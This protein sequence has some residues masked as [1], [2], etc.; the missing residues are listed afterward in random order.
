M[1]SPTPDRNRR[2]RASHA[3]SYPNAVAEPSP[4]GL[5]GADHRPRHRPSAERAEAFLRT[6]YK[7][8]CCRAPGQRARSDGS[9]RLC[10]TT[11][12][13]R[14]LP[15]IFETKHRAD[16]FYG[17]WAGEHS[18]RP[19]TAFSGF[20]ERRHHQQGN[21]APRKAIERGNER[22]GRH[23]RPSLQGNCRAT[24]CGALE[25]LV[26]PRRSETYLHICG[27]APC[28]YSQKSG[29]QT[30]AVIGGLHPPGWV[31]QPCGSF[32][33]RHRSSFF[34]MFRQAQGRPSGVRPRWRP[35]LP[36][37][38]EPLHPLTNQPL[39]VQ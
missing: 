29:R 1:S 7:G 21:R 13:R 28:E 22:H 3:S 32:R 5:P 23:K 14:A 8:R 19:F 18:F 25:V 6:R 31:R 36:V 33:K 27:S 38:R 30:S 2:G 24:R 39:G 12:C 34:S 37:I 15:R 10:Q 4:R 9:S 35:A 26:P 16:R 17:Q 20:S 11:L